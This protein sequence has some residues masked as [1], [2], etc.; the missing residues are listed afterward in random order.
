MFNI[1][2]LHIYNLIFA[3]IFFNSLSF[4]FSFS[5]CNIKINYKNKPLFCINDYLIDENKENDLVKALN[6]ARASASKVIPLFNS[7]ILKKKKWL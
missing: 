4:K 2:I 6:N 3:L 7:I 5:P 1:L